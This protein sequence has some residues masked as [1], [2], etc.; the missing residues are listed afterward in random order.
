MGAEEQRR[1]QRVHA[2]L[3][4]ALDNNATGLTRDVSAS[5]IFFETE[6]AFDR[7]SAICF[8]IDID[9]PGGP[10]VLS[11]RGEIVRVERRE[12]RLGVAVKIL[13][14]VLRATATVG[15]PS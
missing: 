12:A 5:G 4:V 6:A 3:R 1:E 11:C 14:S 7:G 9:T 15:T 2:A 13:E 8:D 10:V